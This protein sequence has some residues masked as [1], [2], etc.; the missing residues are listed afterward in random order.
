MLFMRSIKRQRKVRPAKTVQLKFKNRAVIEWFSK[1]DKNIRCRC[2]CCSGDKTRLNLWLVVFFHLRFFKRFENKLNTISQ[3][4]IFV[5]QHVNLNGLSAACVSLER[6]QCLRYMY[7]F[8]F[9]ICIGISHEMLIFG[10]TSINMKTENP[11]QKEIAAYFY[12]R[13]VSADICKSLS[14]HFASKG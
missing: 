14:A 1:E 11:M 6:K 5:N 8:L 4:L 10:D 3:L 13:S 12:Y 7:H 2:Q 9:H